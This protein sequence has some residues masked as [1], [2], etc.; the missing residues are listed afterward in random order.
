MKIMILANFGMGLYKFRKELIEKLFED[1]H[2]VD[3]VMPFDEYVPRLK[4]L[5]CNMIDIALERRGTNPFKDMKLVMDY[6]KIIKKQKPDI[7][8]TY[9]IKP[10]IYGGIAC[11]ILGVPRI[12]NVTGLGTAVTLGGFTGKVALKLYKIGLKGAKC[13]FFQN[14]P[15]KDLFVSTNIFKGK[16]K[17]IPGSGV[18]LYYHKVEDIPDLNNGF[19]FL[20]IGRVMKAKGVDELIVAAKAIKEK[21][22]NVEFH[23]VGGME[24]DY[25]LIIESAVKQN[26]IKY[27]G[28]Q[29]DIHSFIKNS[30][31]TILPSYHEGTAN[32]LLESASS[33]R[34]VLASRVTGCIETFEE[35]ISGFGFTAKSVDSLIEAIEK[36]IKLD[37]DDIVDMGLKGRKKMENEYDRNIVISSYLEEI[38]N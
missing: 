17:V 20:F 38:I 33:G 22:D 18:N 29:D 6:I 37:Y 25:N 10:N 7:I 2:E 21:Y 3:V 26:I 14:E 27:H 35:G 13:V 8:L 16:S 19:K 34:P 28:V 23:L 4:K 15:N 1:G 11:R 5:G 30:H 24:D 31:C 36:F 9:T 12:S 32:V